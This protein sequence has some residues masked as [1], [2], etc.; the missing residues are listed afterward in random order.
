L[1]TDSG[2]ADLARQASALD[3]QV[4]Q[5]VWL[6]SEDPSEPVAGMLNFHELAACTKALPESGLA[7]QDLAQIVYTSGTESM[8][9]GAML[10]HDAVLWQYVSC[11]VNA[12]IA[13]QDLALHALPLY[14]C[15]QLDVFFVQD[16]Q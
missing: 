7:S 4:K 14:H 1:A 2:L 15:A 10:T 5:F 13:E 16:A 9:K 12:E 8:P 11:V 6:P 3:T